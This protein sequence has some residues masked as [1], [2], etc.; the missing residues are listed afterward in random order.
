VWRFAGGAGFFQRRGFEAVTPEVAEGK[1]APAPG[2]GVG[3]GS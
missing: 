3:G 1:A 2:L